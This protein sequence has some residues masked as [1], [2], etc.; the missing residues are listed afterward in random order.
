MAHGGTVP[1]VRT[2]NEV[3]FPAFRPPPFTSTDTGY[4]IVLPALPMETHVPYLL[5]SLAKICP[6]PPYIPDWAG[7][8]EHSNIYGVEGYEMYARRITAG[9]VP[10]SHDVDGRRCSAV[11]NSSL[12][13]LHMIL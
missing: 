7:A 4:H 9:Q 3:P 5:V 10:F 1:G 6:P 2:W 8:A 13:T 11:T 12:R